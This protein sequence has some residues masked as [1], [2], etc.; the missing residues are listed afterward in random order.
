MARKGMTMKYLF[1]VITIIFICCT[2]KNTIHSNKPVINITTDELINKLNLDEQQ[3][4]D[5]YKQCRIQL[6]DI[7]TSTGRPKD[8]IPKFDASYIVFS[9]LKSQ[10]WTIL[11]YFD[12]IVVDD[13]HIGSSITIQGE[14]KTV[15][16]YQ[17]GMYI[18]IHKC[19]II[20]R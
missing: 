10:G 20:D 14:L 4:I 11:A 3:T 16:R 2:G 1:A 12:Q 6:T 8:N 13:L 9:D 17:N 18:F 7:I 15:E 5:A 19:D